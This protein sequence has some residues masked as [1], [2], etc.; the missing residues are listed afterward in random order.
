MHL[1]LKNVCKGY[2]TKTLLDQYHEVSGTSL[3]LAKL[4]E[5]N[6]FYTCLNIGPEEPSCPQ[7]SPLPVIALEGTPGPSSP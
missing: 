2:L 5:G 6:V 7:L 4:L 3:P 1:E